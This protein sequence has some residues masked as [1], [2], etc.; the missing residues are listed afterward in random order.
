MNGNT[1]NYCRQDARE[2]VGQDL[3]Q[4]RRDSLGVTVRRYSPE[5]R[6]AWNAFASS[7]AQPHFLFDRNYM[8]YHADRFVDESLMF[9][10]DNNLVGLFPAN[11]RDGVLASH[12]GLTFGGLI[13]SLNTSPDLTLAMCGSLEHYCRENGDASLIYKA[14]PPH[15]VL[16]ES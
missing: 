16:Q 2:D 13:T 10:Q 6:D 12:E 11:R 1:G 8:D 9:Y 3:F 5:Y 4:N 14:M 7:S 15:F